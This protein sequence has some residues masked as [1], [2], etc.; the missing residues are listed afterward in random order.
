MLFGCVGQVVH[1]YVIPQ[2]WHGLCEKESRAGVKCLE[3]QREE[4]L[5][6]ISMQQKNAYPVLITL[7]LLLVNES[8]LSLKRLI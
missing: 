8:I 6:A 5:S 4:K 3:A 2:C 7:C 1:Y